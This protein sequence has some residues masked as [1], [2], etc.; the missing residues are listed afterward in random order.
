MTIEQW[1]CI[2]VGMTVQAATFA[3]GLLVGAS[4]RR[5]HDATGQGATGSD[6]A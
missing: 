4:L 2:C 6:S 3:L 5:K 1:C